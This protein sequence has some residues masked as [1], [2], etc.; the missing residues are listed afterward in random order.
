MADQRNSYTVRMA[1]EG[2]QQF[3][4]EFQQAGQA[5]DQ[6]MD[7]LVDS[8]KQATTVLE[9]AERWTARQG[10]SLQALVDRIDPAAKAQRE[11]SR[12]T[13]LLSKAL[14]RGAIS[15]D[16]HR[17]YL[18]LLSERY[19]SVGAAA[20]AASVPLGRSAGVML[21]VKDA[22]KDAAD[23]LATQAGV[24]GRLAA[25]IGPVGVGVAAGGIALVGLGLAAVNAAAKMDQLADSADR[26][27]V[28]VE[29]FQELSFA[30]KLAG[31]GAD[32][33]V[34]ALD[35]L[36]NSIADAAKGTGTAKDTFRAL[37]VAVKNA[38]GSLRSTDAVFSQIAEKL[39]SIEDPAKRTQL[40][41]DLFGRSGAKLL[42][43][44]KDGAA[45]LDDMAAKARSLGLVFDESVVR[46]AAATADQL[47]IVTDVIGHTI[48]RGLLALAPVLQAAAEGF[49]WLAEAI[50]QASEGFKDLENRSIARLKSDLEDAR[51]TVKDLKDELQFAQEAGENTKILAARQKGIVEAETA[52]RQIEDLIKKKEALLAGQQ[53]GKGGGGGLLPPG[54]A[55]DDFAKLKLQ[56]ET[57]AAT[58]GQAEAAALRFRLEHE[59]AADGSAKFTK[60]QIDELVALQQSIDLQKSRAALMDA[61]IKRE[62]EYED[63]IVKGWEKEKERE[64]TKQDMLRSLDDEIAGNAK[65]IDALKLGTEEYELQAAELEALNKAKQAGIVLTKEEQQTVRDKAREAAAQKRQ[66]DKIKEAERE[67]R[68]IADRTS[69][70]VI[71]YFATKMADRSKTTWGSVA[72]DFRASMRKVIA[73]IAAEMVFRPII[74]AVVN[75]ALGAV[76]GT[77]GGMFGAS[78]TGTGV[79]GTT[80]GMDYFSAVGAAKNGYDFYSGS[81]STASYA[82]AD[83]VGYSLGLSAGSYGGGAAGASAAEV[84]ALTGSAPGAAN[85]AGSSAG[86]SGS[87]VFGWLGYASAMYQGY[88][89]GRNGTWGQKILVPI[90]AGVGAYFGGGA[91]AGLGA[92]IGSWIGSYFGGKPSRPD[93]ENRVT[94]TFSYDSRGWVHDGF[95]ENRSGH[96]GVAIAKAYHEMVDTFLAKTGLEYDFSKP[97][98][99]VGR[100][101]FDAKKGTWN[102]KQQSME[103]AALRQIAG[104]IEQGV[105]TKLPPF[106]KRAAVEVGKD[107]DKFA[108]AVGQFIAAKEGLSKTTKDIVQ[109]LEEISPAAKA[110]KDLNAQFDE[111]AKTAEDVSFNLNEVEAARTA[112][113]GKLRKGFN[114]AIADQILA[115]SNPLVLQ[116]RQLDKMAEERLAD[117]E[118]LGLDPTQSRKLNALERSKLVDGFGDSI[119]DQILGITDPVG[120]QLKQFDKLAKERIETAKTLGTSLAEVERLNALQRAKIVQDG[121]KQIAE[122]ERNG[123]KEWFD[124]QKLGD[125]SS[126]SAAQKEAEAKRQFDVTVAAARDRDPEALQRV[127]AIADQLLSASR[128]LYGTTGMFVAQESFVTSTLANL[129][130]QL[131]INGFAQGTLS[132]PA[133][134]AL[135][136]EQGAELVKLP[137]GSRVY[138]APETARMLS[139]ANDNLAVLFERSLRTA[140]ADG[141]RLQAA[142][143]EA[144]LGQL[145]RMESR[146]ANIEDR[147][148]QVLAR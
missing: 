100:L 12:G 77:G 63:A 14:E 27:G 98:F 3:A 137:G 113:I 132:S 143:G 99:Q 29:R 130:K 114:D 136:G 18:G 24:F 125:L 52:A 20:D 103:E 74:T 31:V 47:D 75:T 17:K 56:L 67:R 41:M 40:A 35:R 51:N 82:Y 49:L 30:A 91:G 2:G 101:V 112:S 53:G 36:N 55:D 37:G 121:A 76:S 111:M 107:A 135:V 58:F 133:G 38:D 85:G 72:A 46:G 64:R 13:D 129:A 102:D 44:L 126:L 88:E 78:G 23:G 144:T 116:L 131:G 70:E 109:G 110:L 69:D 108:D 106:L 48:D 25:S 120:L 127:T 83:K 34:G 8:A 123:L 139:G 59:K 141:H 9:G 43:M 96:E 7:G 118:A 122:A 81:G 138:P 87:E 142:I 5:A 124:Q 11:L 39:S 68:R 26:V 50:G 22:A 16:D 73:Q 19:R 117:V 71:D 28:G 148:G 97:S 4:K 86:V 80:S 84:G 15:T 45:G 60:A 62:Q 6:A 146:L 147:L 145:R 79:S 105:F 32:E 93:P 115:I 92:S 128:S 57:T 10:R 21:A 104:A 66:I 94:G 89:A 33:M 65:L 140:F 90:G 54:A 95:G 119:T 1:A 42:P 61:A 134:W